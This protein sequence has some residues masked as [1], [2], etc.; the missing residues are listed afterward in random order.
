MKNLKSFVFLGLLMILLV[1]P[2]LSQNEPAGVTQGKG[3]IEDPFIIPETDSSIKVDGKMDDKAWESALK[4]DVS[5]ESW[6][7]DG[8]PAPI[9][10]YCYL[11]YSKSYLY[12]GF[13]A[14]E[15]NPE[16]IRAYYFE[17]DKIIYDDFVAIFLDTFND[18]RRAYGFRSNPMGVQFDDI[19]SRTGAS[20]AWDAIYDSEGKV[21]SW[22]Y[23]V[24]MAIPFNQLR[25]QHSKEDQ[26]W[27]INA[28]RIYPREVLYNFDHIKVDRNNDCLICQYVKVKGFKDVNP[29]RNIEIVP[30]LTGTRTDTR[31]SMPN[32]KMEKT[33]EKIDPG[34]TIRWGITP[35]MTMIGTFKPDFSQV[36][37]DS[38][39]LDINTPFALAYEERR[40]FFYE[41]SDYFNTNFNIVYTRTMREPKWGWKLTGKQKN[42]TIGAIVVQDNY[43]N[44]IFPASY[45]NSSASLVT[46]NISSIVRYKRDFASNSTIGILITD[47]EGI[48][49]PTGKNYFNRVGGIDAD[50]R[51]DRKNRVGLQ[52]LG[53]STRYPDAV[54]Y[55]Y[56]QKL[57]DFSG[58]ALDAFFSH[59]TRHFDYSF[60]VQNVTDG[61]RADLGY[62]PQVNYRRGDALTSYTWIGKRGSWFRQIA[63]SGK[64][65]YSEDQDGDLLKSGGYVQFYYNGIMQS[66][67]NL[68]LSAYR[69]MYY[70][71]DFDYKNLLLS[72]NMK[73]KGSLEFTVQSNIGRKIDYNLAA[74]GDRVQLVGEAVIKPGRHMRLQL[75]HTYE[76]LD[77]AEGVGRFYTANISQFSGA[78]FFNV[79]TFFR[80]ILQYINY[81]YGNPVYWSVYGTKYEKLATQLLFSYKINP[82]TV[83]FLGYN[84]TY[85]GNDFYN[86]TQKN[87]TFFLKL[88]Y[89][90]SL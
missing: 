29:G 30:T 65:T 46:D 64:F 2:V 20:L 88:S 27:G 66:Y 86:L 8:N 56:D 4:L 53:T 28:K 68:Q 10:T 33:T 48:N 52:F 37:A 57:N 63:L 36:E 83:V 59:D 71:I 6:P 81:D 11:I 49:D 54:A 17:R 22:G 89:A 45:Y 3:S 40:P 61:F 78:Y 62:M 74:L 12:A 18:G 24:E 55:N 67:I 42:N 90:L 32:G 80:A 9:K 76:R 16:K 47:R 26:V 75:N 38:L 13:V 25:F 39:Q 1:C 31:K 69:E 44:L 73:P 70:G 23:I 60:E 50:I 5:F 85:N 58:T 7:G 15:P 14:Y 34:L 87:R 51:I 19:R 72:I 21:Y 77:N 43:T 82:R 84:D 35:N 41:G 79:K